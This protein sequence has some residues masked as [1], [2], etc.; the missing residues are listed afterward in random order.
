MRREEAWSW[1]AA[2]ALVV[3]CG[4]TTSSGSGR[5]VDIEGDASVGGADAGARPECPLN[6]PA[7]LSDCTGQVTQSCLYHGAIVCSCALAPAG[8]R[9]LCVDTSAAG[10]APGAGGASAAGG[11]PGA[12]GAACC[13]DDRDCGDIDRVPCV[14]GVC[15]DPVPGHC[16]TDADCRPGETCSGA[17]V[18]GCAADCD[19]A[20]APGA[21]TST[22]DGGPVEVD[23]ATSTD[24]PPEWCGFDCCPGGPECARCC[25]PKTC[26]G[27][28]AR[29]C[30]LS[31]CRLLTNCDG[32]PICYPTF[33]AP[34]PTCGTVG[35]YG[36][37]AC[38]AGAVKRCG[39]VQVDGSCNRSAGGYDDM[40]MC[41]ACGDGTCD[42]L[43]NPCSC[44]EDCP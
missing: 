12:G 19:Q 40:P 13:A 23:C 26:Q 16:W 34:D 41:L 36:P 28:T 39:V 33:S 24:C 43:E 7:Q 42:T 22:P 20:D 37:V 10:G 4:G 17:F 1:L 21:C 31:R 30:P 11:A 3:A 29:D 38:C 2:V 32:A 6:E 35:Y 5:H 8:P 27:F 44:P 18:C 25:V 9:W 15:K 14:K